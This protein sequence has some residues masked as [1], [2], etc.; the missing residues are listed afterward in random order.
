MSLLLFQLSGSLF[1]DQERR[2]LFHGGG[3]LLSGRYLFRTAYGRRFDILGSFGL[4]KTGALRIAIAK[5][6]LEDLLAVDIESHCTKGTGG[7]AHPAA[8][9]DLLVNLYPVQTLVS[10]D[11]PDGTD[12]HAGSIDTL[13][14]AHGNVAPLP[15]P[16][17]YLDA[18][19]RRIGGALVFNGTDQLASPAAGAF[20]VI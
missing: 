8:D 15:F 1:F 11:R 16:L 14:A 18:A 20:F 6:A 12:L 19:L 13:L 5:I 4:A 7:Y 10:G 17:D 2:S 9:A 3:E